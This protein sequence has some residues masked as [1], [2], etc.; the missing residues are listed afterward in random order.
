M[1]KTFSSYNIVIPFLIGV[2]MDFYREIISYI[3]LRVK[4]YIANVF[5]LCFPLFLKMKEKIENVLT[6][7]L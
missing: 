5:C 4:K 2:Y 6:F 3:I 7:V 1:Q